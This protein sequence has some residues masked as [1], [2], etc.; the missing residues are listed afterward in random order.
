MNQRGIALGVVL[1]AQLAALGPGARALSVR[2]LLPWLFIRIVV[3]S[4]DALRDLAEDL[5]LD[6]ARTERRGR[7][8]FR[9][10]SS[11]EGTS[12]SWR[13]GR[14]MRVNHRTR[15]HEAA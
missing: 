15:R 13:P 4:D 10:A 7:V 9:Q 12:S 6:Q 11:K 5:G 8:W 1:G 14:T 3:D 2:A